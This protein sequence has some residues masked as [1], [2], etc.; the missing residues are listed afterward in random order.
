MS[1]KIV[2]SA[3]LVLSLA[4]A[5]C[6]A[7][8]TTVMAPKSDRLLVTSGDMPTRDYTTLGFVEGIAVST[9]F[10]IPSESQLSTL[11]SDALNL[12]MVAKAEGLGADAIINVE[13]STSSVSS[14]LIFTRTLLSVKGTAIKFR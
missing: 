7:T 11:K 2:F 12:G 9:G 14:Y 6:T 1:R 13:Y 4:I 10:G 3:L 8:Y 5:G